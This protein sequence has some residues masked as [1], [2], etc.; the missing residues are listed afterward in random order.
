MMW[1]E[2][3]LSSLLILGAI[4]LYSQAPTD[5][6]N[7]L[8]FYSYLYLSD[9]AFLYINSNL[10]IFCQNPENPNMCLKCTIF[11]INSS[12]P[13]HSINSISDEY[14]SSEECKL[15]YFSNNP[16]TISLNQLFYHNNELKKMSLSLFYKD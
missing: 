11:S 7:L 16:Q 12:L 9:Q 1:L 3:I 8:G 2:T 13:I 10:S 4:L 15:F 6:N 5:Q 14:F